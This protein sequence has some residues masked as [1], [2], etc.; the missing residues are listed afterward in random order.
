MEKGLL[1]GVDPQWITLISRP[2]GPT[3]FLFLLVCGLLL[4]SPWRL[5]LGGGRDGDPPIRAL[6]VPFKSF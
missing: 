3:M 1:S 4:V 6:T 2:A 5:N